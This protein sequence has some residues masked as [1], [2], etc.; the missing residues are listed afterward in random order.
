[1]NARQE[2]LVHTQDRK[3]KCA[4]LRLGDEWLD[5]VQTFNILKVHWDS[6]DMDNFLKKLNREYDSGYG[7]QYLFGII[8][9]DDGSWSDRGE[10]DGSEW[11]QYQCC[12]AIPEELL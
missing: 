9:Y 1:M 12:P 5:G 2:F 4:T 11:W 6:L 10:Y 3:I 7:G 8:W